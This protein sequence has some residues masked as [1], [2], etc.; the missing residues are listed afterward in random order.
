M[1]VAWWHRLDAFVRQMFHGHDAHDR[2]VDVTG[3][4]PA[5]LTM[6]RA[7]GAAMVQSGRA[8]NDTDQQLDRIAHAYG[9][10][11]IRS[12]VMPTAIIIQL[13]GETTTTEIDTIET[14]PLRL[15]QIGAIDKLVAETVKGGLKPHDVLRRLDEIRASAPRFHPLVKLMGHVVLT[16]GFGMALDPTTAALPAYAVLGAVVGFLRFVG[17]PGTIIG[18]SLPIVAAFTVTILTGTLLQESVR[19]DPVRVITPSLV[20]FLPGLVLTIAAIELTHGQ[21]IA[22]A[23]RVV[24]GLSQL[25]VLAFGVVA[26]IAVVGDITS[27]ASSDQLGWWA[28]L[29]GVLLTA[30]GYTLF[31][32]AP[33]GSLPWFIVVLLTVHTAQRIGSEL[34][35]P[36]LSGFAG[37]LVIIPLTR[38]IEL[39]P[40]GPSSAVTMLPAL[41]LLVPGA[42]GFVGISEAARGD[43]G[44]SGI[45]SLVA[46]GLAMFSISLGVLVGSG[47]VRDVSK[48]K[49]TWQGVQ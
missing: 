38:A 1:A 10:D 14:E 17:R 12:L 42:L 8:T 28:P 43:Q 32:G 36:E 40:R 5:V 49:T 26:G 37:A 19:D 6:L 3:H 34:L 22:G 30:I 2:P 27:R 15:D 20:S 33:K 47:I 46:T 48:V 4:D 13:V 39:L 31:S 29:V 45:E 9:R 35:S 44:G 25:V 16:L 41:W 7:L 23:S 11:E 24:Y 21:V 18:D